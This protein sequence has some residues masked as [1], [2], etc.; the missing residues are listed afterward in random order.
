MLKE[1]LRLKGNDNRWKLSKLYRKK[2]I[3]PVKYVGKFK[4]KKTTKY[5]KRI[6]NFFKKE[7]DCLTIILLCHGFYNMHKVKHMR[8]YKK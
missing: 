3:Q 5:T 1:V 2:S 8:I 4:K 6:F 7:N